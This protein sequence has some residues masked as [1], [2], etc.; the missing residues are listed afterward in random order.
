MRTVRL[1]PLTHS[2]KPLAPHVFEPPH[3]PLTLKVPSLVELA[4]LRTL[5]WVNGELAEAWEYMY[6]RL[7]DVT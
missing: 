1:S 3:A 5:E 6:V 4:A 2:E 7:S